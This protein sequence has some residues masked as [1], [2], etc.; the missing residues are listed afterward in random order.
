MAGGRSQGRD[1]S[2]R[3]PAGPS[4]T[5]T[6]PAWMWQGGWE[7]TRTSTGCHQS[8]ANVGLAPIPLLPNRLELAFCR[9]TEGRGCWW[10][11]WRIPPLT[12]MAFNNLEG[13]LLL[14]G[15]GLLWEGEGATTSRRALSLRCPGWVITRPL[16][17]RLGLVK[18]QSHFKSSV[19]ESMRC[20][21]K[22]R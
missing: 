18:T 5:C 22:Y 14:D 21:H 10:G 19:Y 12:A 17:L 6:F 13:W 4:A 9:F 11:H 15:N 3:N 2:S 20:L 7:H 16:A 8:S 1:K